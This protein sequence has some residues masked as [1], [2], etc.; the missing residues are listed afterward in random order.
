MTTITGHALWIDAEYDVGHAS[1]GRSRYE[2]YIAKN[3]DSFAECW[4]GT[5]EVGL[6]AHFAAEAWRVATGPIMVPGYVRYHRRIIRTGLANSY[7][8]NSLLAAVDLIAPWPRQLRESRHWM[9]RTGRGWWRDWLT[10]L[11]N[12]YDVPSDEDVTK[13][14]FLLTTASLRFTTPTADLPQPPTVWRGRGGPD[15]STIVASARTAVAISIR[16]I[17]RVVWPIIQVLEQA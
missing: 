17:N 12:V 5:S 8:D 9:E 13:A 14:P 3:L 7:W 6:K 2:A 16:E 10:E 1:N 11:G 15:A 4:D